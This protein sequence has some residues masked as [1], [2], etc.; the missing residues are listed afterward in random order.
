[1]NIAEIELSA[2]AHGCLARR[3]P[4]R[5]TLAAELRAWQRDRNQAYSWE[6]EEGLEWRGN[7]AGGWALTIFLLLTATAGDGRK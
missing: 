5:R 6:E 2:L 3:L 4:D 1:M 7:L